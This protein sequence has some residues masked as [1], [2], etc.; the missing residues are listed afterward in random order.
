MKNKIC[1]KVSLCLIMVMM[2]T[3]LP[4]GGSLPSFASGNLIQLSCLVKLPNGMTVP[5]GKT[6][7]INVEGNNNE[8]TGV[9]PAG[10][11]SVTITGD[12]DITYSPDLKYTITDDAG[13][14]VVSSGWYKSDTEVTHKHQEIYRFESANNPTGNVT[15]QLEAGVPIS[16]EVTRPADSQV[17]MPLIVNLTHLNETEHTQ[18]FTE[19]AMT[20]GQS[21]ASYRSVVLP[22]T[23]FDSTYYLQN[24]Y[25]KD[26]VQMGTINTG[27]DYSTAQANV[28]IP[29]QAGVEIS[30]KVSIPDNVLSDHAGFGFQ[31]RAESVNNPSNTY[32]NSTNFYRNYNSNFNMT[33]P[34][35][36]RSMTYSVVV[37]KGQYKLVVQ[38]IT[39][40]DFS[41]A[42][43]KDALGG[44]TKDVQNA[45]AFDI[46]APTS[47]DLQ[48]LFVTSADT[49][50]APQLSNDVILKGF[51]TIPENIDKKFKLR[52]SLDSG[53]YDQVYTVYQSFNMPMAGQYPYDYVVPKA[54][55]D[56]D[57]I[58]VKASIDYGDTQ[59]KTLP[60][61]IKE[62]YLKPNQGSSLIRNEAKIDASFT[63]EQTCNFSLVKGSYVEITTKIADSDAPLTTESGYNYSVYDFNGVLVA[64]NSWSVDIPANGKVAS[65]T[66]IVFVPATLQ[67]FKIGVNAQQDSIYKGVTY[68]GEN[69]STRSVQNAKILTHADLATPMEMI[70]MPSITKTVTGMLVLPDTYPIDHPELTFNICTEKVSNDAMVTNQVKIPANA[71]SVLFALQ[72]PAD[73]LTTFALSIRS[74]IS[75]LVQRQFYN[76]TSP[77][78]TVVGWHLATDVPVGQPADMLNLGVVKLLQGTPI[79]LTLSNP[80]QISE[81]WVEIQAIESETDKYIGNMGLGEAE[82]QFPKSIDFNIEA[83]QKPFMIALYQHKNDMITYCKKEGNQW[84]QVL[85]KGEATLFQTPEEAQNANLTLMAKS[86]PPATVPVTGVTMNKTALTLIAGAQ[87]EV[88]QATVVPANASNKSLIWNTSNSAIVIVNNVGQ[89]I[90]VS[91]GTTTITARTVDG[92]YTATCDVTVVPAVSVI[93]VQSINL[94]QSNLYLSTNDT[95][96]TLTA[97]VLPMNATNKTITWSSSNTAVA[98]I[99]ALTGVLTVKGRGTTTI[100]AG[101]EN[102]TASCTV[103][104]R[105]NNT[106]LAGIV[107]NNQGL[108]GFAPE[109]DEFFIDNY[110][111]GQQ[112]TV[113]ASVPQNNYS[114]VTVNGANLTNTMTLK[115]GVNVF[116]IEVTAENGSKKLNRLY[117]NVPIVITANQPVIID[118]TTNKIIQIPTT[119]T[120]TQTLEIVIQKSIK[121]AELI[122]GSPSDNAGKTTVEVP[123]ALTFKVEEP[124]TQTFKVE[125]PA[126]IKISASSNDLWNGKIAMPT[127]TQSVQE[128]TVSIGV[129]GMEL[130]FNKPVRILLPGMAGKNVKWTRGGVSQEISKVLSADN[131]NTATAELV[132]GVREGKFTSGND[133]VVWTTHFTEFT[134]YGTAVVTPGGN[135]GGGGSDS[136]SSSGSTSGSSSSS[137]PTS[138]SPAATSKTPL[139]KEAVFNLV[140]SKNNEPIVVKTDNGVT[141]ILPAAVSKAL[142]EVI[143]T[144]NA[145]S[146]ELLKAIQSRKVNLL[147][148]AYNFTIKTKE[149]KIVSNFNQYVERTFELPSTVVTPSEKI[150][151]VVFNADGSYR[152]VPTVV[153]TVAGVRKVSLQSLTN[154]TYGIIESNLN[155]TNAKGRWSAATLDR[156]ASA[157]VIS[158]P[159]TFKPTADITRGQFAELVARA[160]GIDG[161][162]PNG[163]FKDANSDSLQDGYIRALAEKGLVNGIGSQFASNETLTREQ[164]AVILV[165]AQKYLTYQTTSTE[166]IAGFRDGKTVSKWAMADMQTAISIGIIKGSDEH[167]LSPQSKLT[168]ETAAVMIYNA[169][170]AASL[171]N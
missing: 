24:Y 104:V 38:N 65:E 98:A 105:S 15:L 93:P 23:N 97:Q 133:L 48:G 33:I 126:E 21:T 87:A 115:S 12:F 22:G 56:S 154:S 143:L 136:G 160:L 5:A 80:N 32:S 25:A 117:V 156:M 69:G 113:S 130:T 50:E 129:P 29:L 8:W 158:N 163:K 124:G 11:S 94:S 120:N 132:N 2:F 128:T 1:R 14:D 30:G 59:S 44:A 67:S 139:I 26:L 109:K 92:N 19:V 35:K 155:V 114:S 84:T 39:S 60:G 103:I 6:F 101:A 63:G 71:N 157:L 46:Q 169:M 16:G 66:A 49:V 123:G 53:Q 161:I 140:P 145:P 96:R 36:A 62:I 90:P 168:Q 68:I 51:I 9:I 54:L 112:V 28:N 152:A 74:N 135:G 64:N 125:M 72:V 165:R 61:Y 43:A 37:P 110:T 3:L 142:G 88:L 153:T 137:T 81:N 102:V 45:Q 167:A 20:A 127:V 106:A 57:S 162:A 4:I 144:I 170:K 148:P 121:D 82:L 76:S 100:T 40:G 13:L 73:N 151:G 83:P 99:D 149:G 164:A 111:V 146:D 85:S 171:M 18:Y 78:N 150:Q 27:A 52:L 55:L 31:V 75:G 70:L 41:T 77:T 131:L 86:T 159:S 10:Q 95:P 166:K 108:Q 79:A 58:V 134:A 147:T 122:L 141:Y 89:V 7:S 116:N 119:M 91:Q 138:S 17:Q 34:P 47:V 118:N 42:Y 107:V